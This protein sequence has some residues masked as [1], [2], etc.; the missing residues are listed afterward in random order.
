M[1]QKSITKV[2]KLRN[3]VGCQKKRIIY[4]GAMDLLKGKPGNFA[5]Q[6]SLEEQI[7]LLPYDKRWEFPSNRLKLG[8][9]GSQSENK[10]VLPT[11]TRDLFSGIQLG[12]GCFG[13]V[14]KAEAIGI[15]G[16]CETVAVKMVRSKANITALEA[17][18]SELKVLIYLGSHLN[19][20]NL[21]GA[22]TKYITIGTQILKFNCA[23]FK[24]DCF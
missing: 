13:R 18:V 1:Y 2:L 15:K 4:P 11:I 5:Q 22:C 8:L 6:Q 23:L 3:Y 24:I 21:L 17:L 19:V 20:V 9:F 7:E 10:I 14:V 12:V 16:C